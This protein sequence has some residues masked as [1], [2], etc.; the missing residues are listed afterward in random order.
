MDE[1]KLLEKLRKEFDDTLLKTKRDSQE[2]VNVKTS[3]D[4]VIQKLFQKYYNAS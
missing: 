4:E 2:Y 3:R 1:I